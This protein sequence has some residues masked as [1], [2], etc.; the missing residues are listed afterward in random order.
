VHRT[1]GNVIFSGLLFEEFDRSSSD[2][3][4][5]SGFLKINY[6]MSAFASKTVLS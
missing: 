5:F 6:I 1:V 3:A 2:S 4:I